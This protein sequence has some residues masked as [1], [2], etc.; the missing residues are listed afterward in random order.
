MLQHVLLAEPPAPPKPRPL[1]PLNP[2]VFHEAWWLEA[3]AGDRL[4]EVTVTSGGRTIGRLPF[5]MR[6]RPGGRTLCEMPTLTH[7]LGPAIDAGSGSLANRA[8]KQAQITREL[9][10]QLPRSDAFQQRLHRGI[11]EVMAFQENGFTASVDF[12]FELHPTEEELIWKG[13]RDKTRNMIRRART[14]YTVEQIDDP[15]RFAALYAGNLRA[16]GTDSYYPP[17]EII[18]LVSAAQARDQGRVLAARAEDGSLV[19]AIFYV[20]DHRSAYYLLSTRLPDS[21]NSAV[22]LLLWE[23][24]CHGNAEGR[25]FDFDGVSSQGNRVFFTGFGG[26]IRPRYVVTRQTALYRLAEMATRGCKALLRR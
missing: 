17:G 9:L 14:L 3:M 20:W 8:L 13:M 5:V 11:E 4:Q 16:R 19:A 23:A 2:T 6:R 15:E 18:R 22:S 10:Q 25:I 12:T 21:D 26:V 24:V 1:D 7:F